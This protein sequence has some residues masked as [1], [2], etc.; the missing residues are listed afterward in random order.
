MF[1]SPLLEIAKQNGQL[2]LFLIIIKNFL[3]CQR[4]KG[5]RGGNF[6][7]ICMLTKQQAKLPEL[8]QW[9]TLLVEWTT[10][11]PLMQRSLVRFLAREDLCHNFPKYKLVMSSE[12]S[13]SVPSMLGLC[14]AARK[15]GQRFG[16]PIGPL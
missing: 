16:F 4:T 13:S 12:M 14:G 5:A 1:I 8:D 15:W 3:T 11:S 10:I 2:E 9:S 7:S 6:T